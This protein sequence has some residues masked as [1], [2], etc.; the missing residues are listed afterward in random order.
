MCSETGQG[1]SLLRAAPP[2][3]ASPRPAPGGV[4]EFLSSAP[5][6]QNFLL[7]LPHLG[8]ECWVSEFAQI[9]AQPRTTVSLGPYGPPYLYTRHPAL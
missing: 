6:L 9:H 2:L 4:S 7:P 1:S 5:Q 8:H 3:P